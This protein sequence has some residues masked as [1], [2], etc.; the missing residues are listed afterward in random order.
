MRAMQNMRIGIAAPIA[1]EPLIDYL[2]LDKD[3][4][5][6]PPGLGG[7]SVVQIVKEL[8]RRDHQVSVY[9]LDITVEKEACLK[10]DNLTIS[11]G[12]YRSRK[13]MRDL[14]R[15]ERMYIKEAIIR[16]NTPFVHAHWTYEFAMGAL[17][18]GKPC[19]VTCRD[20]AFHILWLKR[21]LCRFGRFKI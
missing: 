12:P 14:F 18:S 20:S 17:A 13:R 1:T 11:Y 4:R 5:D 16:S 2:D 6:I 8:L 9:S 15:V 7:Y 10:G 21:D 3:A 19:L